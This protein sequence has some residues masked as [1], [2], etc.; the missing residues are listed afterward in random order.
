MKIGVGSQNKTKVGAVEAVLKDYPLF[1]DAEVIGMDIQIEE[2]GHPRNIT[3][4][5]EGAIDRAKQAYI[6]ND[7]G[8]GIEGGLMAVPHTKSGH[9][10]VAVCAI[11]DGTQVH[12][13]LSPAFEWPKLAIEGILEQG[14]DG[15]QAM[16]AAGLTMDEK[17]GANAGVV[18]LLTDGRIDRAAYN[19][20]AIQMALTHLEHP[21]LF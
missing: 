2:F 7:Y 14:M 1:A 9:M 5:V 11:F 13:G 6:S 3:E 15:S 20:L 4:T 18:G 17:I 19:A 12:L 8:V 21:E 10:E 16:T